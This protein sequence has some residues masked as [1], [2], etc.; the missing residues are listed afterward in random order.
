[1]LLSHIALEFYKKISLA[2]LVKD[3]ID[4][5]HAFS[6]KDAVDCL[7][8]ILRTNDR[9]LGLLIGRAIGLQQFF[10][11]V[12]YE[13]H[14]RDARDK[15]YQ[16]KDNLNGSLRIDKKELPNGVFTLLTDC[17]SPT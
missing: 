7:I 9:N 3:D 10:H 5:P 13:Y 16:F 6:G 12:T 15:I 1:A 11:E 14:L 2:T 4:Y 8:M 17:Y